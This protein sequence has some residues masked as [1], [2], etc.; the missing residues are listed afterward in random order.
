MDTIVLI[1]LVII[2]IILGLI[3]L[4]V[5][6]YNRLQKFVIRINEA[7]SEIDECLR[8]RY[9]LLLD[10]ER[11]INEQTNL[12]QDNLKKFKSDEMSNFE[13]DRKLT[14]ITDL[15]KKIKLDYEDELNI[16]TFNENIVLLKKNNEKCDAS[17]AFYNKYT[18][19]LNMLVKKFPTNIIAR[20]HGIKSR[21]YFDNKIMNDDDICDFKI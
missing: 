11:I 21:L 7:E 8:K 18:T 12:N 13:V 16:Q 14:Q 9:D 6:I 2:L 4:Y 3:S 20:I 10:L 19:E 17:K 1:V 15:F 5:G